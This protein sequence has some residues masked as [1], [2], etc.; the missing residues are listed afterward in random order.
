MYPVYRSIDD[1][2]QCENFT[3]KLNSQKYG[4]NLNHLSGP[5]GA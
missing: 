4:K 5:V 1:L 3:E 2:L